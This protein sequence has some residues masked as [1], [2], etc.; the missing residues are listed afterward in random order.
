VLERIGQVLQRPGPPGGTEFDDDPIGEAVLVANL[1]RLIRVNPDRETL[2]NLLSTAVKGVESGI[3]ME[4]R[5]LAPDETGKLAG[6]PTAGESGGGSRLAREF[7]RQMDDETM[8]KMRA[9]AL[10][11][12]RQQRQADTGGSPPDPREPPPIRGDVSGPAR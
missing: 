11:V 10:E 6:V 7:L 2:A 4:R 5:A 9:W 8:E 3:A 1:Q 12:Q